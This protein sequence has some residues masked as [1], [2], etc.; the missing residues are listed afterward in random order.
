METDTIVK[1]AIEGSTNRNEL[2]TNILTDLR[3]RSVCE[4]G[5]WKGE[6]AQ[7]L[8]E[9][10]CSIEQYTLIDPWCNL[11]NWNKPANRPDIEFENI[12]REA[13]ER[14]SNFKKDHFFFC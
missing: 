6:F 3:C 12:R 10:V 9:N 4:V 11:P 13:L 2:W 5:V 1:R 14:V 8:L 7:T